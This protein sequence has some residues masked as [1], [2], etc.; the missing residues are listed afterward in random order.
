MFKLW[1]NDHNLCLPVNEEIKMTEWSR[2][3]LKKNKYHK[4]RLFDF[5]LSH[6][7]TFLAS[8]SFPRCGIPLPTHHWPVHSDFSGGSAGLPKYWGCHCQPKATA[9]S[10]RERPAPMWRWLALRPDCQV[11]WRH[12]YNKDRSIYNTI[13]NMFPILCMEL[14]FCLIQFD[15]RFWIIQYDHY[16]CC[17]WLN[18]RLLL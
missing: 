13:N 18:G 9:G 10:L 6:C 5:I 4:M 15:Y 1:V 16:F 2:L 17:F 12:V 11:S 14:V 8:L 7:V 3:S